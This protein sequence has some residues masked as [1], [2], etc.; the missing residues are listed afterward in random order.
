MLGKR[1][2]KR[3]GE[4]LAK[5]DKLL[6]RDKKK[7]NK[8]NNSSKGNN[9]AAKPAKAEEKQPKEPVEEEKEKVEEEEVKEEVK[10]EKKKEDEALPDFIGV[11]RER[12][13]N[14]EER[15]GFDSPQKKRKRTKTRSKQKNIKKD[16]RP[17]EL[18][19]GGKPQ[20]AP[21]PAN[22]AENKDQE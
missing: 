15:N 6:K 12:E 3:G 1:L 20:Q 18:R 14:K 21:P 19:P 22:A 17:P 2:K 9:G 8:K 4:S 11:K 7:K 5:V 10:E 13:F 16:H